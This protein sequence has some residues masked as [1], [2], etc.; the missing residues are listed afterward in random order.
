M[1]KDS[2]EKEYKNLVEFFVLLLDIDRRTNPD[3]YKL[4]K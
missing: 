4:K 1:S 3:K 2:K